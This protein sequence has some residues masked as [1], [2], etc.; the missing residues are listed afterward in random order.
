MD[1]PL[2][3]T[4]RKDFSIAI[5]CALTL[6][7][8]AV[9]A[10]FDK[11]WD[12]RGDIFGKSPGDTNA[13][14][15][16]VICNHNVVLAH[17]P[18]MGK[19]SAANVA[20]SFRSS[21]PGIKLALLVGVCG[22]VPY[23]TDRQE[24]LL[25]DVVISDGIVEYDFGR[26]LPDHQFIRK[27]TLTD[28]LS[29]PNV[30]IRAALAKLKSQRNQD[31]LKENTRLNLHALR[32]TLGPDTGAYPGINED[33][34]FKSTYRHKHRVS[35]SCEICKQDG[36][37]QLAQQSTCQQL[38]CNKARVVS[39]QRLVAAKSTGDAPIPVI[40]FGRIA[41]G[42]TVMKS[43][44]DRDRIAAKEDVIAFEMEGAGVWDNLPCL[45]IKGICDYADSHKNKLWQEYAAASAAA[46]MKSLLEH[47]AVVDNQGTSNSANGKY[48]AF[49]KNGFVC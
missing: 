10:A 46:C 2:P 3:P 26:K 23:G 18:S 5:I 17:M 31:R 28:N 22:G 29:R 35:E 38:K 41:S 14:T 19:K 48:L 37:C 33:R 25:G 13:Y 45:V 24:V 47:W 40:H 20:T 21:F 39:R 11:F 4:H 12:E 36:F 27:D 8:S 43:G 1:Q 32:Q 16:G 34:L 7:A 44:E 30:E 42:D 6:E 15:T 9:E 49:V